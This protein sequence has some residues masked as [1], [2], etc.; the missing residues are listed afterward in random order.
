MSHVK[1]LAKFQNLNFWQFK[2][3]FNFDFVLFWLGIWC[4]PLVWVM[5]GW[6][7]G[8][9]ERRHSSC[10][11]L[12]YYW[13]SSEF[14]QDAENKRSSKNRKILKKC[15]SFSTEKYISPTNNVVI[16][17]KIVR[18]WWFVEN[19]HKIEI[20]LN[21]QEK[22]LQNTRK[23]IF[24]LK[25]QENPGFSTYKKKIVIFPKFKEILM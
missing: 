20:S 19:F 3:K 11:S 9:S 24:F 2:K 16:F 14:N 1:F 13:K 15:R 21:L 18:K 12:V 23:W 10:S 8:I 4:E 6:W 22:K 7:G 5:M 17:S 25:F